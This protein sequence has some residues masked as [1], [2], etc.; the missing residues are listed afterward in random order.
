MVLDRLAAD[1]QLLWITRKM[2]QKPGEKVT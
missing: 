1:A 2:G